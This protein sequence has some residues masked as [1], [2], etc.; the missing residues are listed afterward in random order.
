MKFVFLIATAASCYNKS[1]VVFHCS[2]FPEPRQGTNY[3]SGNGWN[4]QAVTLI[5]TIAVIKNTS[6]RRNYI[7]ETCQRMIS[8]IGKF[9]SEIFWLVVVTPNEVSEVVYAVGCIRSVGIYINLN[10]RKMAAVV[11]YCREAINQSAP[12]G[13]VCVNQFRNSLGRA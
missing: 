3:L 1:S 8:V 11:V 13:L 6:C 9:C 4:D 10:R 5:I 7:L 12:I 2:L